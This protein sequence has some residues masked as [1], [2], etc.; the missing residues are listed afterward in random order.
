MVG[1]YVVSGLRETIEKSLSLY[2]EVFGTFDVV[3]EKMQKIFFS[4]KIR[5]TDMWFNRDLFWSSAL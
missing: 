1:D 4:E 2:S 5:V 3:S